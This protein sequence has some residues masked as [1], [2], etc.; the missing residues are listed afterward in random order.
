MRSHVLKSKVCRARSRKCIVYKPPVAF[1]ELRLTGHENAIIL[2]FK[3]IWM[4]VRFCGSCQEFFL[5]CTA[6]SFLG[7]DLTSGIASLV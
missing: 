1:S 7:L 6:A 3:E 5:K 4:A 2:F